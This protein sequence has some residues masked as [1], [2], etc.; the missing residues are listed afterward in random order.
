MKN[1]FKPSIL[2]FIALSFGGCNK[3]ILELDSL[4]E[5]ISATFYSNEQELQLALT[6]AYNSL[7]RQDYGIAYQIGIDNGGS[8]I[9]VS[10]GGAWD[11][12]GAGSHATS[13]TTALSLYNYYYQGIAR[14]NNVLQNMVRLKGVIPDN[15][16]SQIEAQALALRA[17]FY[18]Y[19]TEFFGNV[20]YIEIVAT[21]PAEGLI[22]RTAKATV[23]DKILADLQKASTALPAKWTGSDL[24][25]ITK[26]VALGLRARVALYNGRFAESAASAKAV[27]D[28]ESEAGYSLYPDYKALFQGAETAPEFMLV[29]PFKD[30][31]ITNTQQA[32]GSRNA[33]SWST[34][35]PNQSMVDSYE[36]TDGLPIDE[37]PLYDP[38]FPFKNRDPRLNASIVLPQ[39]VW[40]NWIFETH[41]D[42]GILRSTT[43]ANLGTNKDSRKVTIVAPFCGYIWKKNNIEATQKLGQQWNEFDFPLMRYAEILLT[44]AEAKIELGEIDASVLTAINRT[45]ARAYG[46]AVTSTG[47][48]PAITTTVQTKLREIIRRERKVELANEGFRYF[49]IRRWKIAEKVM[50]VVQYGRILNPK[51]ATGV[52]NID[53]DSFVS[54]A[55]IESQ[56][57]RNPQVIFANA[58]GRIF[59]KNRDYLLPIPQAEIDAYASKGVVLEQNPGY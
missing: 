39:T 31:F 30:Q 46:V 4:T 19:L 26:G 18:I 28:M 57:D 27:M 17:Y 38:H 58:Q 44:Y 59:N 6:G 24:G 35:I 15:K 1:W 52:P 56:Y 23:V 51:T 5:P 37:S 21:N 47:T 33:G 43:G 48:Y 25:R 13:E 32:L 7:I 14:T 50:P 34:M 49:D 53:A 45:R 11:R 40:A 3:Q 2:L 36:A 9:G 12:I 10:R 42:S 55:G 41:P 20:P 54:Y 8:D 22:A 16:Y 29:M